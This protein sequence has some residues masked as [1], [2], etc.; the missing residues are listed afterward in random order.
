MVVK[1]R[2]AIMG[3]LLSKEGCS[4]K[5][6]AVRKGPR[7]KEDGSQKRAAVR[8]AA[9]CFRITRRPW[10]ANQSTSPQY[11]PCLKQK[12]WQHSN[13][14]YVTENLGANCKQNDKLIRWA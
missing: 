12:S 2:I 14:I 4:Q 8:R 10:F 3:R 6:A 7:S 13:K 1:K 11:K 9:A 5:R